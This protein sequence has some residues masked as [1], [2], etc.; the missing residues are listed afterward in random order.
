MRKTDNNIPPEATA[1]IPFHGV[2]PA[3][4]LYHPAHEHDACGI[5]MICSIKNE[6]SRK[7]VED[8]LKILCNLEHRGAVGADP[9]AGDGAG[10]LLQLPHEFFEAEAERLGFQLPAPNHYGVAQLFM[11]RDIGHHATIE[12]AYQTAAEQEG[13]SIIGWREVPVDSS[14]LGESVKPTR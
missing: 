10:I 7:V 13:L 11:P 4:G 9:K 3:Q 8:G 2:K 1:A 5:G 14:I 6:R 12:A